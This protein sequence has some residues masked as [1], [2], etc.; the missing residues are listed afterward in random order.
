MK[1]DINPFI[2]PPADEEID[3]IVLAKI[4]W[5]RRWTVIWTLVIFILMG[6]F[7]ALF[8]PVEYTAKT[9]MVPQMQSK[10]SGIGGLGSLA[11]MAGVN[12][13][14]MQ[15]G[16]YEL[17]PVVYPQIVQSLPFQKIIMHTPLTWEGL[18]KPVSLLYY[19]D[20]VFK[21][22]PLDVIKKYTIGLPG[23]ML[24]VPG[25]I[26]KLLKGSPVKSAAQVHDTVLLISLSKEEKGMR[27]MLNG[28]LSLEVNSK[29]GYITLTA[30]AP[31][32]L[33][34]AQIAQ[35]AMQLLQEQ[36]TEFKIDKARNNLAF[37][38]SLVK[39]KEK[40]F[41][42]AQSR[43]ANFRDSNRKLVSA[44]AKTEEEKLVSEYQLTFSVYSEVAKQL[45]SAK[46]KVKD[47]TPTFSIVEP[48]SIPTEK[49]KPKKP[50]IVI[51]WFILGGITGVGWVFGRHF[52]KEVRIKW[53]AHDE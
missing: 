18:S 44:M 51:I 43:L 1:P 33:A 8:S 10:S 11:A 39:E 41:S 12:L 30:K 27:R 35:K 2:T 3:L 53:E 29:E 4:L 17:S 14:A 34:A 42:N 46:I 13:D 49:S 16:S 32:A 31:E 25:S 50:V 5:K 19:Y 47:E 48:V 20:S 26:L 21:P 45:E 28:Q 9:I 22:N 15:G 7:V 40:E 52:I 6:V 23:L 24:G 38:K 37:V 36:V